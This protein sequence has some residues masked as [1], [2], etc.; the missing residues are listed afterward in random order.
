MRWETA[1]A[2]ASNEIY[3]LWHN[4]KKLLT[5]TLHPFS[6][7]ARV[8][9]DGEKRVFLVRKEGFRRNKTVIRNEYGIKIGEIGLE[10]GESFID[11]NNERFYYSIENKQLTELVLY[12]QSKTNPS[13]VCGLELSGGN[14]SWHISND[15]NIGH[16]SSLLMALCWYMFLPVTK[17]KVPEFAA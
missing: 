1:A 14:H 11:V 15:K 13:M 16:H 4:D 8:E 9:C 12:K 2:T 10:N 7:S 6:N 5:L 17:E 3:H